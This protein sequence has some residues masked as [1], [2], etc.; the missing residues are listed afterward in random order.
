MSK[1]KI[2]DKVVCVSSDGWDFLEI[3]QEYTVIGLDDRG[4]IVDD[5]S[6]F[7]HLE[8]RF[9]LKVDQDGI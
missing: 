5:L 4:V 2:G 3:G 1:F 9:E 6:K 8:K 7:I